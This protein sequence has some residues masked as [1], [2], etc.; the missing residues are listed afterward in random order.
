MPIDI[1]AE[2]IVLFE[3]WLAEA[4]VHPQIEDA[5]AMALATAD[6]KGAPNVRM[7]LLKDVV[8]GAF[9]FYTNVQSVKA[10]EL[11]A[12]PRA[13]LCFYWTPLVKQVRVQ[14]AVTTTTDAA[15]DLY[16]ATRP[17]ESQ[18]GAW[19]ADQS[20]PLASREVL[21]QR[22][23]DAKAKYEGQD[24][25]R[26]PYWSGYRLLPDSIEFWLGQPHRLHD[27]VRFTKTAPSEWDAQRLFP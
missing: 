9:V 3:K 12:N 18:L 11:A 22:F 19:A 25:P 5:T 16:F 20:R 23:E 2:P 8:E 10:L 17:R 4:K 24:V 14:G 15:A 13:A 1:Q 7:V 21:I 27:R 6:A 26:P